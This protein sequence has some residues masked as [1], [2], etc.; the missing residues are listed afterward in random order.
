MHLFCYPTRDHVKDAD[1]IA[2]HYDIFSLDTTESLRHFHCIGEKA[3]FEIC[4][5]KT[6]FNLD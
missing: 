4:S 6:V 5:V 1:D 2:Q 3:I